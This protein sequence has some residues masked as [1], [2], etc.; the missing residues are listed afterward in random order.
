MP[1]LNTM[2]HEKPTSGNNNELKIT[3]KITLNSSIFNTVPLS[4]VHLLYSTHKRKFLQSPHSRRL[5]N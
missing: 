3:A 1:Q 2:K 4:F 5:R